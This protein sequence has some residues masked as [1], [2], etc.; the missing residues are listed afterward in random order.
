MSFGK[1]LTFYLQSSIFDGLL[2][3][4][5][6]YYNGCEVWHIKNGE[7]QLVE[8]AMENSIPS[9]QFPKLKV[10]KIEAE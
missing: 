6:F 4:F 1:Y 5:Q 7:L 10:K 8:F 3:T 9:R 2:N